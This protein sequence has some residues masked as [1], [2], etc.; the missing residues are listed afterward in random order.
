[1]CSDVFSKLKDHRQNRASFERFFIQSYRLFQPPCPEFER[2]PAP[3]RQG[4]LI[5]SEKT[6]RN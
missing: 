5:R 2:R 4:Y 6:K 3:R 1:M